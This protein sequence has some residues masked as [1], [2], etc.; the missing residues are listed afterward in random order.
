MK[1]GVVFPQNEFPADPAALH[2]FTQAVEGL[3][4]HHILTYDHVLGA[5]PDRPGGKQGPYTH[6]DSFFEPFTLFSFMAAISSRLNFVTGI[7]ILPQRQTALVAKQAAT[8]DVLSGGRFRLGVGTGWNRVEYEALGE[9]FHN[10]GK[11]AEEQVALLKALWQE[12]LVTFKGKWHTVSD[13]G[14]NPLPVQRPI[15]IW[16][17]GYVDPVLRRVARMGDGWFPAMKPVEDTAPTIEKLAGF[18]AEEGR[19]L[20]DIGIEP[21]IKITEGGPDSWR[22]DR[23]AWEKVGATHLSLVTMGGGYATPDD[24]LKVL[25]EAARSLLA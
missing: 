25:Q 15:P 17:G 20:S 1:I 16:F 19:S 18:L 13:A 6:L 7:L 9:N 22:A 24:H 12:P 10:R 23:D 8:L 4:F 11:R 2:A 14:L 21:R 3:G 5:S